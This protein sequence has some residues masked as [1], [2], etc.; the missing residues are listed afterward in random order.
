[1][2]NNYARLPH[3]RNELN[4]EGTTAN[5]ADITRAIARASEFARSY[6]N[7]IFHTETATAYFNGNGKTEL[8]LERGAVEPNRADLFSVT[9]LKVDDNGDGTY[10]LTLTEGSDYWLYPD[11]TNR[12]AE[13]IDI[14][15]GRTTSPQVPVWPKARR[16]IQIVGS[17]GHSETWE[18]VVG[19]AAVTGS[20][21]D[22]GADFTLTCS[23]SVASLLYAGDT[24]KIESEQMTVLSVSTVTAVVT[25][26]INGTTGAI[27]S[28]AAISLRRFP[29]DLERAVAKDAARYLWNASQGYPEGTGVQ[30]AQIRDALNSYRILVLA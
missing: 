3:V 26:A 24:I 15:T 8:W 21:S 23:E 22:T 25:R 4:A 16:S 5:D 9:T 7:R 10:E 14:V 11:A 30:W 19:S 2:S 20:L 6:T 17:W 18:S 29:E 12:A 13:R 28:G 27:H 1:M